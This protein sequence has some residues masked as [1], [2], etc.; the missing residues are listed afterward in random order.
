MTPKE[1]YTGHIAALTEEIRLLNRN[2]RLVVVLELAAV[3]LAVGCVVAYT[4]WSNAAALVMA[5]LFIAAYVTIR[6]RDGRNSRR[7][8][9]KESLRSVYQKELNYLGGDYS[10][11]LSGEQYVNP[12]HEF[13]L[14]L[15]IFG[16]QSLF[17]RIN[18]TV[19][20]GGSDFLASELAETR[21][22]TIGEIEA[23]REAIRE[24][25]EREPLRTAFMAQGRGRQ[26]DTAD[27]LEAL[28]A[29]QQ[30]KISHLAA[31]RF[32]YIVAVGSII[33]FYGLLAGA[34]FG[35]LSAS[36]PMLWV[37][38]QVLAVYLLFGRTLKRINRSINIILPRLSTYVNMIMLIVTSDLKS[39]EGRNIISQ[40]SADKQDALKSF[41][42]LKGIINSLDQRNEIWVPISNALYLADYFIVRRFLLW[43]DR[44]MGHIEE[45]IAAVSHFDALVSMATFRYN[46][47]MATDAE[48]V[49]AD[50]VVYEA[51]GLYHPFLGMKAVRNDFTIADRHYYIVTGAN[52]AGKSTFLRSV[53]INYVLACCGLPVFADSLRLSLFSL[54]SSMRTTDDLAHGISYFNA[55]LLRLQQLIETC[56]QN[57]HTLIILDEI[58]KGTNSL[59]KLNGSRLFLQ[60]V[61]SLPVTG[62]IATHDLELSKMQ[63]Q[64]PDRFHNYCFEIRLS[65]E[66]TYTYRLTEGVA[67]NQNATY[68]L[69]NILKSALR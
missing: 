19:T 4:M 42:L 40:L 29:V 44:Y 34:I 17:H 33:V 54:F 50:E 23:R 49:D 45:W 26:I 63:Q 64:Y 56:R 67:R 9:E 65:D 28:R 13:S 21:V 5:A 8:D 22:R 24:L 53:G 38:L 3:G 39:R 68:L 14:D 62:I 27:I 32:T 30:L 2:N 69:K 51:R 60:S 55:E 18:R 6:R 48:L 43:Q 15:D 52:M 66:I 11:F 57:R 47:P 1:L 25:A 41:R 20:T 10:G 16:P 31:H 59:D 37:L 46:E 35:P 7:S 61:A 36:F 12:R 58:L